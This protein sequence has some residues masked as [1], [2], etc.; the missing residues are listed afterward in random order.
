[1]AELIDSGV[2]IDAAVDSDMF[3]ALEVATAFKRVG[4]VR[5]LL[6]VGA[7]QEHR[8]M[9]NCSAAMLCWYSHND[10][11][12]ALPIDIFNILSEHALQ[13]LATANVD[14]RT[15]LHIASEHV[16]ALQVA[17][18]VNLG[19]D[20]HHLD[21]CGYAAINDATFYGNYDGFSALALQYNKDTTKGLRSIALSPLHSVIAGKDLYLKMEAQ[22]R[23]RSTKIGRRII[24]T[25]RPFIGK[26]YRVSEINHAFRRHGNHDLIMKKI[27]RDGLDIEA[28][29]HFLDQFMQP[30]IERGWN[31]PRELMGREVTALE[32]AATYGPA[33]EA[34]YLNM[35]HSCGLLRTV[36]DVR[37]L[38][39]LNKSGHGVTGWVCETEDGADEAFVDTE[40]NSESSVDQM[41]FLQQDIGGPSRTC[42]GDESSSVHSEVDEVEHFY[43]AE[44]T[45]C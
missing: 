4:V 9:A 11:H 26:A 35:L 16:D 32:L 45:L 40:R 15:A 7:S 33:T 30:N 17:A 28:R 6:A 12:E 24:I 20:V 36:T 44:E 25:G 42:V 18:L 14:G 3:T 41:D 23:I 21:I 38:R 13:D 37:R 34:W 29:G 27:L 8:N 2:D 43:D 19:G 22:Q 10:E 31:L 5:L 39:E 1:M